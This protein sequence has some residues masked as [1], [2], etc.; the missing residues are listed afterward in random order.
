MVFLSGWV[1]SPPPPPLP[2]SRQPVGRT[3]ARD[4]MPLKS[5]FL[6]ESSSAALAP[7][8]YVFC[9]DASGSMHGTPWDGV[10]NAYNRFVVQGEEDQVHNDL[11][12]VIVFDGSA[13][14]SKDKRCRQLPE[15]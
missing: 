9:L 11:F 12:S 2:P 3:G 4:G 14:T 13:H 15:A 1:A 5:N 6:F 8:H 10:T 7:S